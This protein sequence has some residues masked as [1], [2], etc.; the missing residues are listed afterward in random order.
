MVHHVRLQFADKERHLDSVSCLEPPALRLNSPAP[1]TPTP[2]SSS[3]GAAA[4][5][6]VGNACV[7][8]LDN[9]PSHHGPAMRPAGFSLVGVDLNG[10]RAAKLPLDGR[11][12][13]KNEI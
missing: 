2:R 3:N 5:C 4:I 7:L 9:S 8:S 6:A 13:E 10:Q 12:S 11:V 1:R